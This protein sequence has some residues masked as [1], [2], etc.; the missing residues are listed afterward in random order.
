MCYNTSV[1]TILAISSVCGVSSEY[2]LW[3]TWTTGTT[4][5]TE[6]SDIDILI[7]WYLSIIATLKASS[8]LLL[9]HFKILQ[10]LQHWKPKS[11]TKIRKKLREDYLLVYVG[12]RPDCVKWPHLCFS[13][14]KTHTQDTLSPVQCL[15]LWDVEMWQRQANTRQTEAHTLNCRKKLNKNSCCST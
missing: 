8:S 13:R 2:W 3:W 9:P 6:H 15:S 1:L 11:G 12:S 4:R 5:T 10:K 14:D 7:S